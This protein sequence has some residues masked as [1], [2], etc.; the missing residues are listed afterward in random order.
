[1]A[2]C[3]DDMN[4]ENV[5]HC[6]NDEVS[7]G[8]TTKMLYAA[9][10]H[11]ETLTLPTVTNASKYIDRITIPTTGIVPATGKGF[12]E[13][14]LLVDM[15]EITATLVGSKGNKKLKTDL[16]AY[17]P[18]FR[19]KVIGFVQA[20]RNTPLIIALKDSSGQTWIIGDKLNPA[21]IDTAEGKTGKT[22]EENSGV[23]IKIT[24]NAVP[25]LYNGTLTVIADTP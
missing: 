11:I 24:S 6:P 18:G 10:P 5:N 12:K 25:R 4:L 22:Y 20:H 1:M 16:D 23:T 3:F 17:I 19:G 8:V 14:D 2:S 9:E 21:Y 13:M 15:N 7:A